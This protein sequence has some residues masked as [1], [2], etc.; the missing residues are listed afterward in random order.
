[1]SSWSAHSQSV[2]VFSPVFQYWVWPWLWLLCHRWCDQEN[3]GVWVW[4][5]DPGCSRHPL[6][7]QRNDLQFQNQ[8]KA[9]TEQINVFKK[10]SSDEAK[11]CNENDP[12]LVYC[13]CIS[14]SSYHKNLLASS[15]YEGTV[16]LWDGFTGHRSKVYQVW[17]PV[18]PNGSL[19]LNYPFHQ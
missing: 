11:C 7:C 19:G 10:A 8:V 2:T 17:Y 13:S 14:W 9:K 5:C 6:P 12:N 4:H 1:M 3:Q 18:W 15:D 16:I